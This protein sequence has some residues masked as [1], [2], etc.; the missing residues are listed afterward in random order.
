MQSFG[1]LMML[2]F[3]RD[4]AE[5]RMQTTFSLHYLV[6]ANVVPTSFCFFIIATRSQMFLA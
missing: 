1:R 5:I 6:H 2:K 4:M 3:A